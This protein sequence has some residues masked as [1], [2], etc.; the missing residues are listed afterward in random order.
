MIL[1]LRK[2]NKTVE[3]I[4][5]E[6]AGQ[7]RRKKEGSF[8][9]RHQKRPRRVWIE[10]KEGLSNKA[11]ILFLEVQPIR[12]FI[13]LVTRMFLYQYYV[14]QPYLFSFLYILRASNLSHFNQKVPLSNLF[15]FLSRRWVDAKSPWLQHTSYTI[16]SRSYKRRQLS[17]KSSQCHKIPSGGIKTTS[18]KPRKS[19]MF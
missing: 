4:L 18:I 13:C 12:A 5:E 17:F 1:R 8:Y 10:E 19:A 9:H 16:S 11:K 2:A 6:L 3:E 15:V 7:S 14:C